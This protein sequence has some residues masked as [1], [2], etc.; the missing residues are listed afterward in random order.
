MTLPMWMRCFHRG[1]R[2]LA[3]FARE[4]MRSRPYGSTRNPSSEAHRT[5]LSIKSPFAPDIEEGAVAVNRGDDGTPRLFPPRLVSP[6]P[7][8]GA[9]VVGGEIC[10]FEQCAS[11]GVK[12]L[13]FGTGAAHRL[14][15]GSTRSSL[16]SWEEAVRGEAEIGFFD[17]LAAEP[18]F[19]VVPVGDGARHPDEGERQNLGIEAPHV[20]A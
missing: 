6:K 13:V 11:L 14:R 12:S 17:L 20:P 9:K 3:R 15:L 5:T 1:R 16:R 2:F 10:V 7:R 8:P 18:S 19:G 4:G